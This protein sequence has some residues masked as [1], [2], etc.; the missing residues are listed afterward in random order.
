LK[1]INLCDTNLTNLYL[2]YLIINKQIT[3]KKSYFIS[4]FFLYIHKKLH[5]YNITLNT[6]QFVLSNGRLLKVRTRLTKFFKKS[7]KSYGASI[8]ALNKLFK[9]KLF[10]INFF[11]CK[12]FNY[13]NYL[14]LKKLVSLINPE[15]NHFMVTQGWTYVH[16]YRRRIKKKILR[17]LIKSSFIV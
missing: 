6:K 4:K 16:K 10:K 13:K 7:R 12:N 2:Y 5:Y 15:I 11:F 14:W 9:K 17:N 1:L 8:T 3:N